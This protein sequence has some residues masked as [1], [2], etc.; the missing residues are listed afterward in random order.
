M[1][2]MTPQ[3]GPASRTATAPASGRRGK[4]SPLI[5]QP[6]SNQPLPGQYFSTQPISEP[7]MPLPVQDYRP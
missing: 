6:A 2:W 5:A 1:R 3:Y 4:P 7:Q